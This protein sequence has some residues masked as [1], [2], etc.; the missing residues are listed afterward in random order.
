MYRLKRVR[1]SFTSQLQRAEQLQRVNQA[2]DL[3]RGGEEVSQEAVQEVLVRKNE[4]IR[5]QRLTNNNIIF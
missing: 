3:G 1:I 5:D 2:G 4:Y